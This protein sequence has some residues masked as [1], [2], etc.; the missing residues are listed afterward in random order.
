MRC[1]ITLESQLQH[2]RR[3]RRSGSLNSGFNSLDQLLQNLGY[4]RE[5]AKTIDSVVRISVMR[6]STKNPFRGDYLAFL[7]EVPTYRTARY[8]VAGLGDPDRV[9]VISYILERSVHDDTAI[10]NPLVGALGSLSEMKRD[11]AYDVLLKHG[12]SQVTVNALI[13]A[14]CPDSDPV[15]KPDGR[16]EDS[17]RRQFAMRLLSAYGKPALQFIPTPIPGKPKY[18]SLMEIIRALNRGGI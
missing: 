9:E 15:M 16:Q 14:Y 3:G 6:L 4:T 5:V 2:S 8:L 12:P 11:A 1:K 13:N 18:S 17:L 10:V 7:L